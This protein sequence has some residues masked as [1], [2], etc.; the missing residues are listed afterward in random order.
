MKL[1][2]RIFKTGIAIVLALF[3]A[4]LMHM[5]NAVFAGIAA[6]FAIKPTIYRSY[7]SIIEQLQGNIIGAVVGV[8]LV[9]L[10]NNNVL[11]V[12]L[13]AIITIII[14]VRLKLENNVS[15]G[16]VT[17]I[18]LMETPGEHFLQFAGIR[19]STLLLGILSAFIVN[20]IF[21]PPKYETKLYNGISKVTED[22]LRWVRLT[23]RHA[24]EHQLLKK[25]I[26]TLKERLLRVNEFL[27][28]Y[29]E[30][31]SYFKKSSIDKQ[32]KAVVYRQMVTLLQSSY[33]ILK[34]LHRY[35]QDFRQLPHTISEQLQELLDSIMGDH[36]KL[37]LKFLGKIR[38]DSEIESIQLMEEQRNQLMEIFLQEVKSEYFPSQVQ[39]FH[40]MRL[41]SA[42]VEYQEQLQHFEKLLDSF[43]SFHK[44]K[45]EVNVIEI[46]EE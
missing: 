10:F 25:D 42:I 33:D 2:A 6:I 13:G 37:L 27:S 5:P 3:L 1:G 8:V 16:L 29:K 32:R 34:I 9:M 30:E 21:L 17:M 4:R 36:E 46:N 28:M 43:Q 24:A 35:E 39:Q 44:D 31:R 11:V 7:L 18:A 14:M 26:I 22:V 38:K 40:F 12:G 41:L 23:S 20:L 15:L 19:F 45:N